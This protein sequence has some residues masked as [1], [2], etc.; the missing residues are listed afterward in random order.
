MNREKPA[1]LTTFSVCMC[2]SSAWH[3]LGADYAE[4][5]KQ[6]F[7]NKTRQIW[8]TPLKALHF[9]ISVVSA[10]TRIWEMMDILQRGHIYAGWV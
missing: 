9:L 8:T 7:Q 5:E 3:Q 2:V 4:P 6:I 1:C 10:D